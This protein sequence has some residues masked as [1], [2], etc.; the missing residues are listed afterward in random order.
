[1][2]RMLVSGECGIWR[3]RGLAWFYS[4]LIFGD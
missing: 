3:E 1:M 2:G 4:K